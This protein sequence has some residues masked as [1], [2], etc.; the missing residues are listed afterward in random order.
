MNRD[1]AESYYLSII[2][3]SAVVDLI[4]T[5]YFLSLGINTVFQNIYYF[6][7]V[8][9]AY[10]YRWRGAYFSIV[11][12][13][14]YLL[15][16]A[17]F[18]P[19]PAKLIDASVR[20][21]IF[22]II[23]FVVAFLSN[24]L[25][26]ERKRYQTIFSA[27]GSGMIVVIGND[28]TIAESNSRFTELFGEGASIQKKIDAFFEPKDIDKAIESIDEGENPQGNEMVMTLQ[29][30]ERRTCIVTAGRLNPDEF[31]LAIN[32]ITDRKEIE[33]ALLEIGERFRSLFDHMLNGLSFCKMLFDDQDRP[34][35]FIYLD[36]NSAFGSLTGLKDVVGKKVTEVIPGIKESSPEL[37][38]T[39]GRVALTGRPETFETHIE[40]LNIWL[41][42]SVYSIEK[43]SFVAVFE[44]VT[45][46]KLVEETLWMM[47]A[48][49]DAILAAVPDIMTEVDECK[50]ITWVNEPGIQFYGED[51]VGHEASHYF[52]GEQDT[53]ARVQPLFDG[54]E[55]VIQL[56]SWQRRKDGEKRLLSR[57]CKALKD[58]RGR[59]TG[60][61]SSARD[62]TEEARAA[63]EREVVHAV[64][65]AIN[66]SASLADVLQVIHD[67]IKRVMYAENCFIALRDPGTGMISYPYFV[68]QTDPLPAPKADRRG[69]A[70]YVMRTARPLLLTQEGLGELVRQYEVEVI[71]TPPESWMGVPLYIQSRPAGVLVVQ[72]YEPGSNYTDAEKDVLV[73]IG[74]Q[75]AVV[76]ERKLAEEALRDSEERIRLLLNS[77]AEGIYGVD[78]NGNCTF[79]NDSCLR[80]LGYEHP[81]ELLG[82]NM[83][84]LIHMVRSDGTPYPEEEC[85]ICLAL[86]KGEGV[87]VDDEVFWRSDG[88]CFPV[89][90]LSYPQSHK[91]VIV[92]AVLSFLNVTERKQ[93][94]EALRLASIKLGIMNSIT[95][96]DITNQMMVVNGL[97]E[98]C[99]KREKDP[100]LARY[101]D[102]MSRA[103]ANVQEQIAFTKDYQELGVNAP[104][105]TSLGHQTA[106]SFAMLHPAGVE[107]EDLT[108]G[109][110]VLADPLAVKVPYNLI[111]NSMRHG[112]H[113]TR[114]RISAEQAGDAMLI[115]Y[116]DDGVGISPE[117]RKHL[118][119]KGFGKNTGYG[120]FLMREILAITCITIEEKGQEGKGVRF[121]MRVPPGKWRR[122]SP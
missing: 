14:T 76:I 111:D 10:H 36:V 20:M 89:E 84:R 6:T 73:A 117:D 34:T 44:N 4:I 97:L 46:R 27:P 39:Y 91:G 81:D 101:L 105:W 78:I 71:G 102:K 113:V 115:A 61:L 80:Q 42:I 28:R 72:S 94:E 120:L 15:I 106:Q 99:R 85:P 63:Q 11:L 13:V 68:D 82:K 64:G 5:I 67:N 69:L 49:K 118:F 58:E 90:Y 103:T 43:G 7:I 2:A 108:E 31:V 74:N 110:E 24:Q 35:D 83:H 48:R 32:D 8:L 96:H 53:D 23:A 17:I 41:N 55:E 104:A 16:F 121:E 51:V 47:A 1:R 40:Q 87:H 25:H 77:V 22:I 60:A 93:V 88:T 86:R 95:R 12:S 26:Q 65:E 62:I 38:E 114:I 109:V 70:E 75:A 59:V 122:A 37:L 50:R 3:I 56:E 100:D 30:G 57:R 112:G 9:A 52:V 45:N 21:V 107:L 98:L 116:Q 54:S 66:T 79:C 33:E 19:E 29:T 18:Y 119:E 92:E